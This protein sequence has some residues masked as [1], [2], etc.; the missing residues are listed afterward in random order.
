LKQEC[1]G[2]LTEGWR[3]PLFPGKGC[4]MH[5]P[6]VVSLNPHKMTAFLNFI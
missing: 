5:P 6:M 1:Y 3:S 4:V 2:M